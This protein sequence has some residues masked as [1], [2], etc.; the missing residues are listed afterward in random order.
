MI[1]RKVL[2]ILS[3]LSSPV[4][5]GQIYELNSE[6][7]ISYAPGKSGVPLPKIYESPQPPS[8]ILTKS[9]DILKSTSTSDKNGNIYEKKIKISAPPIKYNYLTNKRLSVPKII[10]PETLQNTEIADSNQHVIL[11]VNTGKPNKVA[12]GEPLFKENSTVNVKYWDLAQNIFSSYIVSL[13]QDANYVIWM[14]T[15]GAGLVVYDGQSFSQYSHQQG[16]YSNS[17]VKVITDSKGNIWIGTYNE[18]A[19]CFNGTDFKYFTKRTGLPGNRIMSIYESSDGKIWIGSDNGLTAY[20]GKTLT[21]YTEEQG[22]HVRQINDITEDSQHNLWIG[23]FN[24]GLI[25]FNGD[26]FA[27]YTTEQGLPTNMIWNV[28]SDKNYNIWLGSYGEG[29]IKMKDSVLYQYIMNNGNAGTEILSSTI[30]NNGNIWFG[31]DGDGVYF[32]DGKKIENIST[33][34]GL[35]NDKIW[36]IMQDPNGSY[37]IASYGGGLNHYDGG[38]FRHFTTTQGLPGNVMLSFCMDSENV[39]WLGIWNKGLVKIEGDNIFTYNELYGINHKTIWDIKADKNNHLWIATEGGGVYKF[40]H[41]KF[42]QYTKSQGLPHNEVSS[43]YIDQQNTVWAG[44]YNGICGIKTD[45]D[46]VQITEKQGLKTREVRDILQDINNNYW[47]ASSDSGIAVY[48][49]N[50]IYNFNKKHGLSTNITNNLHFDNDGNLWIAT[51]NMLNILSKAFISKLDKYSKLPLTDTTRNGLY[52]NFKEH[53]ITI[54]TENGLSNNQIKNI[55]SV[56]NNELWIGTES[57]ITKLIKSTKNNA[58][59]NNILIFGTKH[60]IKNYSYEEGFIGGDI[61]ASNSVGLDE[62][63]HIWWG[64]GK[65]ISIYNNK[66]DIHDT[67]KPKLQLN[68]LSL[69]YEPIDWNGSDSTNSVLKH[70]RNKI[71]IPRSASIQYINV[72]KWTNMPV[73]LK[74]SHQIN[75]LTFDFNT[76]YW[77]NKKDVTYSFMLEGYDRQWSSPSKQQKATY[78]NLSHGKYIFHVKSFDQ[79]GIQ[80]NEVTFSFTIVPP[81]W[82]TV[83]FLTIA[84]ISILAII[85]GIFKWRIAY[86]KHQK[87]ELERVVEERTG[88]ILEK[89]EELLQQTEEILA[90]RNEIEVKK[91]QLETIHHDLTES[92]EYAKRI[93][94]SMFTDTAVLDDVFQEHLLIFLPRDRVSGDFYWWAKVGNEII[95]AVAD[96]TGHGVPGALMSML[97]ISFLREIVIKEKLT[98]P[99]E[100]LDKLREEII[101]TLNQK[102]ELGEQKDGLDIALLSVNTKTQIA[103]YAGARNPII[104][105]RDKEITE[106]KADKA[107]VSIYLRM[108]PFVTQTIPLTK[109]DQLFMFSDGYADQ[110]G[111]VNGKKFKKNPFKKLMLHNS[112]LNM[113]DQKHLLIKSFQQ[114]KGL[115]EQIDDIVIL[116]IKI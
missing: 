45:G 24:S 60:L 11:V 71:D 99:G 113:K 79:S 109:G 104:L 8:S 14:G 59:D 90:Q 95:V 61:F 41:K 85:I 35:T 86:Y 48:T 55:F 31:T 73:G 76:T 83:W 30:D 115:H 53:I 97:G 68:Q 106:F 32:F 37:W 5:F 105:I 7:I 23:T 27:Q 92:L 81:W 38:L 42:I 77:T 29:I 78:N 2:L 25:K 26:S 93:Q 13:T 54:S 116:G 33:K 22:L 51:N 89:N 9:F 47:I 100:I 16:L 4:L 43:L 57:G 107:P 84:I 50:R 63:G 112:H 64:T 70:L 94:S 65:M 28:S 36:D 44:T 49:G 91:D 108:K 40:D 66:L 80:S 111:G 102:F 10:T 46:I 98:V 67:L 110:F 72:E 20:N 1:L 114:W 6:S 62:N 88:Q 103:Q 56:R 12:A 75:H 69:F 82:L 15:F 39:K 58:K 21:V 18:G 96:C 87:T 17:I 101:N 34:N 19:I 52:K 3:V 74:L